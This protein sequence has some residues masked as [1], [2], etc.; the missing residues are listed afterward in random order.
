[1]IGASL[2]MNVEGDRKDEEGE[3]LLVRDPAYQVTHRKNLP[4]EVTQIVTVSGK[5]AGNG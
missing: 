4:Q 5:Q 3:T 2:V 1:M